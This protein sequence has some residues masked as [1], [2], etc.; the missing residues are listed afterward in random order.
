M[1]S[2][3]L[4]IKHSPDDEQRSS[5]PRPVH[6][7]VISVELVQSDILIHLTKIY[8]PK[9]FLLTKIKA[10]YPDILCNPTHFTG[11]WCLIRQVPLYIKINSRIWFVSFH[12]ENCKHKKTNQVSIDFAVGIFCCCWVIGYSLMPTGIY[13]YY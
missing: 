5:G 10:E 13:W 1:I 3:L 8:G 9:V 7:S 2:K 6:F 12:F 4:S 11:P